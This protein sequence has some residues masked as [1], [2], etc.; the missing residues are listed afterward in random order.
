MEKDDL[1]G[2]LCQ[3]IV[4]KVASTIV[5]ISTNLFCF[6]H[7]A[8]VEGGRLGYHYMEWGGGP[9][10]DIVTWSGVPGSAGES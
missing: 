6:L 1:L 7:S 5:F 10:W 8:V 4:R 2:S 3:A 9:D